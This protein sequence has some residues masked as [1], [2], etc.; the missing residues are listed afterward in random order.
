MTMHWIPLQTKMSLPTRLHT[1]GVAVGY[2]IAPRWSGAQD[3]GI[4]PCGVQWFC[5]GERPLALLPRDWLQGHRLCHCD[6]R[7]LAI[8][9]IP[10]QCH[11]GHPPSV[12]SSAA[13]NLG[14]KTKISQSQP[15]AFVR[16]WL[17]R[18]DNGLDSVA[19]KEG[20]SHHTFAYPRR[21]R[22]L[23]YC[24]PRERGSRPKNTPTSRRMVL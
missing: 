17:L 21:C 23:L 10:R 11:F 9:R 2:C 8:P 5:R 13:R 12:I 1:H 15:L 6:P 24:A 4:P 14:Q 22:G 7:P 18:N 20:V 3:P 16:G 19:D